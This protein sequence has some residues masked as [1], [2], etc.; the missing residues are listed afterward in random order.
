M[1]LERE[2]SCNDIQ[3]YYFNGKHNRI[4]NSVERGDENGKEK[5]FKRIFKFS[6]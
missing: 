1:W 4:T 2:S 3:C 6:K 5:K